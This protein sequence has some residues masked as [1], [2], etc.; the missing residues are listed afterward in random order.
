MVSV[1]ALDQLAENKS[2]PDL[3]KFLQDEADEKAN[4]QRSKELCGI[5]FPVF[6]LAN[7]PNFKNISE[8]S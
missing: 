2:L 8:N 3:N 7:H 4:V 6:K 5:T 1:F